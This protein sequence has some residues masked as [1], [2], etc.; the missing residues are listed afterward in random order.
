MSPAERMDVIVDFTDFEDGDEVYLV[1][2][3]PDE[4]YNGGVQDSADPATTGQVM[5]FVV[6]LDLSGV[7][8]HPAF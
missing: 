7:R 2:L 1:N 6:N 5:K 8:R 4:P 3:G